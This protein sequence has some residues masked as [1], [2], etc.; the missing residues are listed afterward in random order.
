MIKYCPIR[1]DGNCLCMGKLC[2]WWDEERDQCCMLTQALAAGKPHENG[3]TFG[4]LNQYIQTHR[5]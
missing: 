4:P 5:L 2:A 1:N 3:G